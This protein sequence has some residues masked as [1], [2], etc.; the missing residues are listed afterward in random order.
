M[1]FVDLPPN[2]DSSKSTV[3]MANLPYDLKPEDIQEEFEK[4][5][6]IIK[7]G[8]SIIRSNLSIIILLQSNFIKS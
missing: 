5:G 4:Y 7:Y 2:F 6:K 3:Y 1:D 8:Y